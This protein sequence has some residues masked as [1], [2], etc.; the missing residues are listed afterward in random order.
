MAQWNIR[1]NDE[2]IGPFDDAE[3]QGGVVFSGKLADSGND[4]TAYWTPG[5]PISFEQI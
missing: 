4:V 5:C 2:L 3:T 1:F